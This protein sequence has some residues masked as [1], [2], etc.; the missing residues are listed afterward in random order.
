VAVTI[1]KEF[2][3]IESFKKNNIKTLRYQ[4]FCCGVTNDEVL[5]YLFVNVKKFVTVS[6]QIEVKKL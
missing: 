2:K 6:P 1:G 5:Y 3:L 4:I